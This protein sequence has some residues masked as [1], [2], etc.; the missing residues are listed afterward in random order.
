MLSK[1]LSLLVVL[2]LGCVPSGNDSAQQLDDT[3]EP[4]ADGLGERAQ[5]LFLALLMPMELPGLTT[6]LVHFSDNGCP[7]V[8]ESEGVMIVHGDCAWEQGELEGS[9]SFSDTAILW[10]DWSMSFGDGTVVA[11][12]GQQQLDE[13]GAMVSDLL[14]EADVRQLPLLPSG[15]DRYTFTG[16]RISDWDAY[17]SAGTEAVTV[18]LSGELELD[19]LERFTLSGAFHDTAVCPGFWDSVDLTLQGAD[20]ITFTSDP[21]ICDLCFHWELASGGQGDFCLGAG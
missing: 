4:A 5:D 9:V 19:S 15:V 10:D 8:E 6:G 7:V 12:S 3:G 18:E 1:Q 17:A 20:A 16:H 11:V 13:D 2:V 21:A 14:V